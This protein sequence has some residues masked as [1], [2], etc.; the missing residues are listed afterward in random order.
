LHKFIESN[1]ARFTAA[2]AEAELIEY[3]HPETLIEL[4]AARE[5]LASVDSYADSF[6]MAS[7]LH[8]LHGN[9]PYALSRR[10]HNIMP[11]PPKGEFVYKSVADHTAVKALRMAS[12][13]LPPTYQRGKSFLADATK[14]PIETGA[15]DAI[16]TSPPFH[17]NRDFLRM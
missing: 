12:S 6:V 10:S 9:R 13:P 3:Y 5:Y 14:I 11:W 1:K 16:L 2:D 8:I 15:I 4:L 17:G 7:L